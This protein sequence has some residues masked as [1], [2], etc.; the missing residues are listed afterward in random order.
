MLWS[1]E[2][3]L[4]ENSFLE[5]DI[6]N[7]LHTV[8]THTY[9]DFAAII[10]LHPFDCWDMGHMRASWDSLSQKNA[11][12]RYVKVE[13]F[14]TDIHFLLLFSAMIISNSSLKIDFKTLN[15]GTLFI[16]MY[17]E[18]AF[19]HVYFAVFLISK[20]AVSLQGQLPTEWHGFLSNLSLTHFK[21]A[22]NNL[23]ALTCYSEVNTDCRV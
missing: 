8:D 9:F 11:K 21:L 2:A 5:Q 4:E 18:L 23:F 19:S 17:K 20:S 15:S 22:I 1:L 10:M 6:K 14:T 12:W 13:N 3:H 7:S 16:K